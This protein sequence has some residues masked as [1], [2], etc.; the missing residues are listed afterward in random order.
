MNHMSK[1]YSYSRF[2]TWFMAFMLTAFA[3]GCGGGGGGKDPILGGGGGVTAPAVAPTVTSTTPANKDT[4]V[5]TNTK[6]NAVFSE[7][8]DA[9]SIVTPAT[10]FSVTG[11]GTTAVPGTVTYTGVT[12][13]FTPTTLPLAINT[14]YTATIS[15]AAKSAAGGALASNYVWTFTTG[16]VAD[17]T[18]PTVISTGAANGATGLPINRAGTATFSEAMD[19]ASINATTFTMTT[20]GVA[21]AGTVSYTGV[22]ATSR[23]QPI[24]QRIPCIR[25]RSPPGHRTSPATRWRQTMS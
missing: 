4:G 13:T 19:P 12:A 6:I 18:A 17:T 8:M 24:S 20:G 14:T 15:T 22:T 10:T 11:P 16:A 23:R 21:V 9:S 2:L 3:A 25:P 5:A 7:A 1:S